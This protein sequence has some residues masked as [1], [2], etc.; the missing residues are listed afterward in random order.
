MESIDRLFEAI[1]WEKSK[2]LIIPI[3]TLLIIYIFFDNFIMPW[4]TRHGQVVEVPD[5]VNMTFEGARTLLEQNDLEIVEKAKKF[6]ANFRAGMVISQNPFPNIQVKKGR[7]IYVIVS[8]GEPTIEMPRLIGSSE[9]NAVFDIKRLGL[10]I[11]YV[12]YEHSDYFPD[13]VVTDQSIPIGTEVKV[14]Q[15]VDLIVSLG[16]FPDRF[17]VPDLIGRSLKDAQ[18]ILQ[19]AGLT[20][21]NISYEV[22]NDLLPETIIEQSLAPG[23]EVSRGDT[24]HVLISKLANAPGED[25]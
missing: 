1:N 21:G 25:L 13:G 3:L 23:L 19:Q 16:L 17:I 15:P 20:F 6:D 14:G 2:Y 11:R 7:R 8:K 4:Y 10:E 5:I 22:Q 9:K 12:R 24:L 18:K